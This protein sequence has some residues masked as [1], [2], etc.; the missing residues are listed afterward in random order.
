MFYS[1][2]PQSAER[3]HQQPRHHDAGCNVSR[4]PQPVVHRSF[5]PGR[6]RFVSFPARGGTVDH[7]DHGS[8]FQLERWFIPAG[9]G[10]IGLT[11]LP[12]IVADGSSSRAGPSRLA[13]PPYSARS[14]T[15]GPRIA[16]LASIVEL[17][18]QSLKQRR[19]S[20]TK[21][22][23]RQPLRDPAGFDRCLRLAGVAVAVAIASPVQRY[24]SR[25]A[26]SQL[27]RYVPPLLLTPRFHPD[28]CMPEHR[29]NAR[30]GG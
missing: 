23:P 7:V 18:F 3:D 11:P 16:Q 13:K 17:E 29:A 19:Y 20:A 14:R 6:R 1:S 5:L 28:A 10:A 21:P 27:A 30:T 15:S 22:R 9:Y 26:A 4:G 25:S 2:V 12:A 24:V 8:D